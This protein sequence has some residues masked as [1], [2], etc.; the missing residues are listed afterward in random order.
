MSPNLR[1]ST[2]IQASREMGNVGGRATHEPAPSSLS[3]E[4]ARTMRRHSPSRAPIRSDVPA[5]T[6]LVRQWGAL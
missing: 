6:P 2:K 4:R 5:R 1:I 3:P